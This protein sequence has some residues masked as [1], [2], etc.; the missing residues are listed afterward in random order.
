MYDTFAR[1]DQDKLGQETRVLEAG[2]PITKIGPTC[3]SGKEPKGKDFC[4]LN[5]WLQSSL[6]PELCL[7]I[8][9]ED[10]CMANG[11]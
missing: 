5:W 4:N 6:N 1:K 8:D 7:L 9:D 3:T 2:N 11:H 10:I